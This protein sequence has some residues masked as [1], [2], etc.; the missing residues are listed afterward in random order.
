EHVRNEFL[1]FTVDFFSTGPTP[2]KLPDTFPGVE[3]VIKQETFERENHPDVYLTNKTPYAEPSFSVVSDFKKEPT[4][5]YYFIVEISE[6][7]TLEQGRTEF[8][9]WLKTLQLT[10]Q[11]INL[12]DIE[13]LEPGFVRG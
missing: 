6:G 3:E 10:E 7:F 13:Y 1:P 5:H 2:T 12:L 11:Q 9:N 4:G 8:V